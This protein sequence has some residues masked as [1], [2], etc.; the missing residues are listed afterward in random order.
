MQFGV[1]LG[2]LV[3]GLLVAY[4][5]VGWCF[6]VGIGRLLDRHAAVRRHDEPYPHDERDHPAEP[7]AASTRA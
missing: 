5:G 3:G 2:P 1:L 4:V 7:S 6:L